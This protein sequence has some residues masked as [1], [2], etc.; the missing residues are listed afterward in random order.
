[1]QKHN[2]LTIAYVDLAFCALIIFVILF[3][4]FFSPKTK[5][6]IT[7]VEL[8]GEY[9]IFVKWGDELADDVDTYMLD[10]EYHLVFFR[11]PQDGFMHLDRDDRGLYN[12]TIITPDGT[13]ITIKKNEEYIFLRGIIPGEY[14]V[15]I[16]MFQR[17]SETPVAVK[18]KLIRLKKI[19]AI[20]FE[21]EITLTHAGDEKTA[22]RF[23]LN[24]K[25]SLVSTNDIFRSLVMM[26]NLYQQGGH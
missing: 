13:Q 19:N 6:E 1:M 21:K 17:V 23:I 5:K 14:I 2:P 12:D 25:G 7:G 15:N 8:E 10:P 22:F 16:H 24:E 4:I 20:V 18:I 26:K 3:I 9:L 11:R